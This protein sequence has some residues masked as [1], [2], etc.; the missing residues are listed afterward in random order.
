MANIPFYKRKAFYLGIIRYFLGLIMIAYGISKILRAQIVVIPTSMWQRPLEY[1]SGKSLAWAF[2]GYSGW[3][4]TLLGLLEFFPGI[5]LLFR[6]T[7]LAG[8]LLLLPVTLNV[9]L[10]NQALDLWADT[11]VLSLVLVILNLILIL[12]EWEKI[13]NSLSIILD[14]GKRFRTWRREIVVNLLVIIGISC[15][16]VS[17]LWSYIHQQDSLT[18][19]WYHGHPNEWI[20]RSETAADSTF[21]MRP[22][23][24]YFGA[25]G[26]YSELNDTGFVKN[27][28]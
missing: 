26:Q 11:K 6:R 15:R 25:N 20:L 1:V 9:Y 8:S 17:S 7:T 3:F 16:A 23:R 5:L 2:L 14:F 18:G 28:L 10:I 13:K 21:P 24:C 12:L 27:D 19:D 22:L 4:Q